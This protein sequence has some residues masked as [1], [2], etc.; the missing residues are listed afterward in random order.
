M[1]KYME[2]NSSG[3]NIVTAAPLSA[4][5]CEDCKKDTLKG[6]LEEEKLQ[7]SQF[8]EKVSL[9]EEGKSALEKSENG[10]DA[11][12]DKDGNSLTK[13]LSAE[14]EKV[15]QELRARDQEVRAH[16]N[17]HK[18]AAGGYATGGP[19]YTYQ[20]GPDGKRYAIGGEVQIDTSPVPNDPEAT[21][22][23]AQTIR[24]AALA[25]AEPSG[26]DKR[27]AAQAAV[28]ENRARQELAEKRREETQERVEES[29]SN[30]EGSSS[31]SGGN[32]GGTSGSSSENEGNSGRENKR[33]ARL[34]RSFEPESSSTSGQVIDQ[35]F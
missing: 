26:Q 14:E 32:S 34:I 16:E 10:E 17:A 27:V 8:E 25:P 7:Q 4:G 12:A 24:R 18:A 28:I 22:R 3:L 1:P 29:S 33:N 35:F 31:I 13:E 2:I 9:S 15:V 11:E 6:R 20:T 19:T 23:K 21:I 5:E 30:S